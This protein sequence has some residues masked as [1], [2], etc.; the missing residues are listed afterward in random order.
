VNAIADAVITHAEAVELTLQR[1][2]G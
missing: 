1:L 2:R